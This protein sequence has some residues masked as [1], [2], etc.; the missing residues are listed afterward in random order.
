MRNIGLFLSLAAVFAAAQ[1]AD[2]TTTDGKT[3]R[4]YTVASYSAE[5]LTILHSEGAVMV[6]LEHWPKDRRE[7]ISRYIRRIEKRREKIR[8]RPDLTTKTGT[9]FKKYRILNFQKD[10]VRISHWGG[11]SL[12]KINELPD[13]IQKQYREEIEKVQPKVLILETGTQESN[14]PKNMELTAPEKKSRRSAQ[15]DGDGTMVETSV[16]TGKGNVS[17][18][19]GTPEKTAENKARKTVS[20][21]S[22]KKTKN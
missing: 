10:D 16:K 21:S 5:G 14:F 17:I 4:N 22:R 15:Q 18:G 20:R 12:V 6:P 19:G 11:V 13:E 7:E 1:A 2:I 8:N 9:V 3:Y